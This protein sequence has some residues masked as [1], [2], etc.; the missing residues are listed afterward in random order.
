MVAPGFSL[1]LPVTNPVLIFALAAGLATLLGL[2]SYRQ[3]GL[4]AVG[5]AAAA[6]VNLAILLPTAQAVLDRKSVV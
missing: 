1:T 6:L 5:P 2:G 3:L 4:G